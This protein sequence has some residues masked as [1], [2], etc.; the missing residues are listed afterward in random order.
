MARQAEDFEQ[1]ARTIVELAAERMGVAVTVTDARGRVVAS[2]AVHVETAPNGSVSPEIVE[3]LHVPFRVGSLE[4]HVA[5]A[6]PLGE[7]IS[8]HWARVLIETLADQAITRMQL[9]N[10]QEFKNK[11]IHDLLRGYMHDQENVLRTG[12][13]LGMDLNLPRAVILINASDYIL[14]ADECQ[15][16]TGEARIPRRAQVVIKGVVNFFHLPNDTI[17][18][19]IGDGEIVVLKASSTHDLEAWTDTEE[20]HVSSSW[21]N[22]TA[23]KRAASALLAKL[24]HETGGSSISI[25]IGRYHPEIVGLAHSYQ[26]ARAALSLGQLFHGPNQVHCLD[27]LGIAS[28]VGVSDERTKIDL[29]MHLLSPLDHEPDLLQTLDVFFECNCSSTC[30][31][32]RLFIHRNTLSYRLDKIASLTGLDPRNFDLAVQIRL[33]LVLRA[34]YERPLHILPSLQ[35]GTS[36]VA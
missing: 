21:T 5:L 1:V 15:S 2:G 19:D 34:L 18:A 24:R 14:G 30:T 12:Q 33:S 36:G 3:C 11:F 22:L 29:A 13:L 27:G 35:A 31:A 32:D 8:P 7:G 10:R 23:L 25:G 20:E 17:C 28:F 16:E 6:E 4:G 9:P 26:D